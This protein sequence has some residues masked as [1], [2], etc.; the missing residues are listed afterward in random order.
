MVRNAHHQHIL[1]CGVQFSLNNNYKGQPRDG[2]SDMQIVVIF[3]STPMMFLTRKVIICTHSSKIV[4]EENVTPV[5][6][7]R[8]DRSFSPT[9]RY[10]THFRVCFTIQIISLYCSKSQEICTVIVRCCVLMA[11]NRIFFPFFPL[12]L[13]HD[14]GVIIGLCQFQCSQ[15]QWRSQIAK[16]MGPTWGPPGSCR[17][18]MGPMLVPW[19][20][21]SGDKWI[22]CMSWQQWYKQSK[23]EQNKLCAHLNVY[24]AF[25][26]KAVNTTVNKLDL[27]RVSYYVH[28]PRQQLPVSIMQSI[29]T[30]SPERLQS[31]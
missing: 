13:L 15:W 22:T 23:T 16:F 4:R 29:V 6:E 18:Q 27:L 1:K 19:T 14:M 10:V 17:P 30:S 2:F 25:F 24:T 26:I 28:M 20:L 11:R 3:I 12:W 8:A 5:R 9:H 21:L 31:K 7:K